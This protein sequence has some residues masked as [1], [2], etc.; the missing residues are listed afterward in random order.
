MA[1]THNQ[2]PA[3]IQRDIAV[4]SLG[5]PLDSLPLPTDD[6]PI[7]P[8][9]RRSSVGTAFAE[10]VGI[11]LNAIG[12]AEARK[13]MSVEH[14]VLG[15]RPP[16]GSLAAEAQAAAAKHPQV[17]GVQPPNTEKLKEAAREDAVRILAERTKNQIDGNEDPEDLRT[18]AS[19]VS[20]PSVDL[21]KISEVDARKLMSHEHRA[22]GFRPPPGSLAAEAQAAAA[23]HPDGAV[24]G[25][26][27]VSG[28]AKETSGGGPNEN[29][30]RRWSNESLPRRTSIEIRPR[31]NS[32]I[33]GKRPFV[34]GQ[35]SGSSKSVTLNEELL[36]EAALKD[37]ERIKA[38][39]GVN[40]ETATEHA[41]FEVQDLFI[42]APTSSTRSSNT[43]PSS[44]SPKASSADK[45]WR[46]SMKEGAED[47]RSVTPT[48]VL[49]ATNLATNATVDVERPLEPLP[50]MS[51]SET[52]DSV[53]I[54]G[55][56]YDQM[57]RY[58]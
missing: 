6:I 54:V 19:S 50:A 4:S 17:S 8:A 28:D 42:K 21:S 47:T 30:Q 26:N 53:E 56:V 32:N 57:R 55:D 58:L 46:V 45:N 38:T 29:R 43:P 25:V 36:K 12:R 11:D 34:N 39:R 14:K 48:G 5:N 27:K 22:L 37:A 10:A 20:A 1:N 24:G 33:G 41:H 49:D 40:G 52:T 7:A 51:R 23:K 44:R 9:A 31:R 16:H 3:D 13:I 15:F 35:T 18:T 2:V